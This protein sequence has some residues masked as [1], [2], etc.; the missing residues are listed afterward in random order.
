MHAQTKGE[1]MQELQKQLEEILESCRSYTNMGRVADYIP[2][3]ASANRDD[4]GI[5]VSIP[6]ESEYGGIWHAGDWE[7]QFT[8]QSICK[9][10]LLLQAIIDNG[11]DYVKEHVGME[12]TGKPFN[13]IDYSEH[14]LLREHINPMVNIGAIAV[15]GMIKADSDQERFEKILSMKSAF[16]YSVIAEVITKPNFANWKLLHT[17]SCQSINSRRCWKII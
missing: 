6:S 4:I 8:I 14:L 12:A 1:N 3:L 16:F 2:E 13:A 10:I 11:T 7:K 5:C 17:Y 15:C 9:P